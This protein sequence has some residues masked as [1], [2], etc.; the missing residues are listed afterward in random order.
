MNKIF[1]IAI[2]IFSISYCKSY[3]QKDLYF[4]KIG[5]DSIK[6]FLDESGSITTLDRSTFYRVGKL[7]SLNFSFTGDFYDYS[8]KNELIFI[9]KLKK[10]KLNGLA[11]IFKN[12][13]LLELGSYKNDKRDSIWNFY[14]N[15]KLEKK[16]DFSGEQVKL[17]E[18][19]SEKGESKIENGVCNYKDRIINGPY[20]IAVPIKGKFTNGQLDGKWT[21]GTANTEYFKNGKFEK[22][23]N[24]T[25]GQEYNDKS[26]LLLVNF[27]SSEYISFYY[28]FYSFPKKNNFNGML[29]S[30]KF[31]GNYL[32][33]ETFFTKLKNAIIQKLEIKNKS[34][35]YLIEFQISS[36]GN[37]CNLN[38]FCPNKKNNTSSIELIMKDLGKWESIQ[39]NDRYYECNFFFPIII[40]NN[41]VTFPKYTGNN[42]E[43]IESI[44]SK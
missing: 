21:I 15:S 18:L 32:L 33:E 9:G 30:P 27:Y 41:T 12:G 42:K 16:L 39:Y 2:F 3:S 36:E 13:E 19:Y 35:Y 25:F 38:I 4:E 31:D 11:K 24:N 23:I 8:I 14:N 6:M 40:D 20:A 28:N 29:T 22:G 7:D 43:D 26:L 1:F 10:S 37:I 34:S 44:L 17:C 5:E